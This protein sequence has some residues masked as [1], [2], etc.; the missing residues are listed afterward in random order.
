M[1][2]GQI[3]TLEQVCALARLWYSDRM[4]PT[5]HG[6]TLEQAQDIF[7]RLGLD[8]PFWGAQADP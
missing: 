4:D 7:R 5:F 3:L 6:K 1:P 2:H 8:G